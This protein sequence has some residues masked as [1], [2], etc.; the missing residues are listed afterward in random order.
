MDEGNG[1]KK[2]PSVRMAHEKAKL[3]ELQIEHDLIAAKSS[4]SQAGRIKKMEE[5]RAKILELEPQKDEDFLPDCCKT[6]LAGFYGH[7][8][9]K[10]WTVPTRGPLPQFDKGI[11]VEP[12]AIKMLSSLDGRQYEKNEQ[13]FANVYLCGIPDVVVEDYIIEVKNSYDAG[14]FFKNLY[15][16]L[17]ERYW[18]QMQGYF[19]L[20]GIQ[21]GEVSFCL[22]PTPE[23]ILEKIIADIM[24]KNS[25]YSEAEIRDGFNYADIPESDRRIKFMVNRDDE[26]ISKIPG[27]IHNCRKFLISLE[28]QRHTP[29]LAKHD[30]LAHADTASLELGEE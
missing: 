23:K 7:F 18:W 4:R 3:A 28:E 22:M 11:L 2:L 15:S 1:G 30:P 20:T 9:Y 19:Y 26:A 27:K 21:R 12:E 14:T 5:R 17:L 6:Y 16:G 8:K 10:K 29:R 25:G 13:R 24:S